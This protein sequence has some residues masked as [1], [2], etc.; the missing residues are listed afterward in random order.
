L[1]LILKSNFVFQHLCKVLSVFSY[2]WE[3]MLKRITDPFRK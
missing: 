3:P 2:N 1:K